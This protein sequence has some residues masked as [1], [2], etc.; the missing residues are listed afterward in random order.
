MS[1][2]IWTGQ[3]TFGLV[4]VPVALHAA[5]RHT[6]IS[7]HLI[8]TRD[9]ARVRYERVNEETGEE[10]PWDKIAKAYEYKEGN[11]VVLTDEELE[12]AAVAMTKVIEIEK[13]VDATV[14]DPLYFDKPYYLVPEKNGAK[15][16]VLLRAAL[17]E[18]GKIGISR[19]VTGPG[20]TSPP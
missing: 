2:P 20:N 11:Y 8:D 12:R 1:R 3:I 5:E 7:F 13:F 15:G 19:V 17:E 6:D 14:I 16:Y 4:N 18:S 10:V 9:S